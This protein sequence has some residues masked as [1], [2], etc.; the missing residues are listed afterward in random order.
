MSTLTRLVY[1][2]SYLA[3]WEW[4]KVAGIAGLAGFGGALLLGYAPPPALIAVVV[5]VA[6]DFTFQSDET[7][8]LKRNRG[9]HL[10]LHA[11]VAGGLPLALAGLLTGRCTCVLAWTLV[12]TVSHYVIDWM[13]KFGIREVVLGV[14]LDQL[15]HLV[16]ILAVTAFCTIE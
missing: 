16:V 5:H 2:P 8:A 11:L 10:L 4:V 14:G 13:D 6:C 15:C 1:S 12:G 3:W 7:A 9:R